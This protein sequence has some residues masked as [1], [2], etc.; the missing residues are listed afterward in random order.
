MS[1]WYS[2]PAPASG[3][4]GSRV[5]QTRSSS[6]AAA[7]EELEVLARARDSLH[8]GA[9]HITAA[10]GAAASACTARAD[11]SAPRA[12]RDFP[13]RPPGRRVDNRLALFCRPA[14][15]PW[16]SSTWA[17]RQPPVIVQRL[18]PPPARQRLIRCALIRSR[19]RCRRNAASCVCRPTTSSASRPSG[20]TIGPPALLITG[21]AA[22]FAAGEALA[23][24]GR[25]HEA[26]AGAAV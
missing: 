9:R 2:W 19:L 22:A 15:I 26:T 3:W 10:L 1:C 13:Q 20:G 4:H 6:S 5:V 23:Q 18:A 7:G 24:L 12:Q 16:C 21:N 11:P 14:S 25:E 17:S 8:R